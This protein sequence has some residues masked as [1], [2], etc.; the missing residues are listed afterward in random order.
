MEKGLV[1]TGG[2][3]V[4]DQLLSMSGSFQ[5]HGLQHARLP[6]LSLSLGV[7]SNSCPLSQ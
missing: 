4:F 7:F 2:E 5:T 1:D 6:C 3:G